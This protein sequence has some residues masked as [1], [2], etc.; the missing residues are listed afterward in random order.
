V[1]IVSEILTAEVKQELENNV[2]KVI[3]FLGDT[4][5]ILLNTL[6]SDTFNVCSSLNVRD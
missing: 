5:N 4:L 2:S 6:F 1:T 3:L